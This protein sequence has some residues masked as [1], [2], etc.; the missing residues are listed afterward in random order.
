MHTHTYIHI[1]I[2]IYVF[3]L[4]A[5]TLSLMLRSFT[6][7]SLSDCSSLSTHALKVSRVES[8]TSP[9]PALV[10]RERL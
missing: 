6:H 10:A 9:V 7:T 8:S 2:H 4:D 5:T 3:C 1:Y